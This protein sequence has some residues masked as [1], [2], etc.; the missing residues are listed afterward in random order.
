MIKLLI[1]GT[2]AYFIYLLKKK[3]IIKN[4]D[5]YVKE[6]DSYKKLIKKYLDLK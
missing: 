5:H 1:L 4:N 6:K 2:F 3:Y